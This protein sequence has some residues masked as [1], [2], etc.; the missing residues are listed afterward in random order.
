VGRSVDCIAPGGVDAIVLHHI[1]LV[2]DFH[3]V[4]AN[5]RE[6]FR[7]LAAGRAHGDVRELP[8]VT[9]ASLGVAFQMFNAAFLNGPVTGLPELER[10]LAIAGVHFA[11]RGLAWSFWFCEDWLDRSTRKKLSQACG[12]AG[13]RIASELPGMLAG[14]L[15]GAKRALP[16]LEFRR[17]ESLSTLLDFR[18]VGGTCF[19]VPPEW[20]AEVFHEGLPG[21]SPAFCC[22]VAYWDGLPVATAATLVSNEVIGVYN[23]AT[24][25]GFRGRGVA[26]ATTRF[27]I[28]AAQAEAKAEAGAL[29]VALQST[30][31][32]Y[33]MYQKLGFREVGRIVVFNSVG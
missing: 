25:P 30:A 3:P 2:L 29:P 18:T 1:L 7:V 11:A 5:L 22:W 23:I 17:V 31:M 13:L 24:M 14:E 8:G 4:E 9:I 16:N 6:S 15:A 32:G 28:A 26:E 12:A 27:V 20:F 33:R 21:T 19:R 10:R